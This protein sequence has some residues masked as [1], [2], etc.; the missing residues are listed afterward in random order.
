MLTAV[1]DLVFKFI[2]GMDERKELLQ[3][4]INLILERVGLPLASTIRI[5][6]PFN[7]RQYAD[8]KESVLDIEASDDSGRFFD[9]EMQLEEQ[10][11]YG[12]R[13]MYY[14]SRVYGAQLKMG[15][16]YRAL[17]PVV[18]IH[19]LDFVM[20]KDKTHFI[21]LFKPRDLL[22]PDPAGASIL[23]EQMVQ[24][25]LE[26]PLMDRGQHC[27]RLEKLLLLLE[28]EGGNDTM[29]YSL[30]EQ[31]KIFAEIDEAFRKFNAD[32]E[33]RSI[34]EGHL[35]WQHDHATFLTVARE[36]GEAEG[37]A[38]GEAEGKRETAYD[39]ARR[40]KVKGIDIGLIAE[41]TGLSPEEIAKS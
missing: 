31:E 12:S 39:I 27:G 34:Y 8:D 5:R 9:I 41:C 30:A 32:P 1:N 29:T 24:I 10:D 13:A 16:D 19:I 26:L 22:D 21:K 3:D 40:M 6:N 17:H 35:K 4:F 20:R 37:R 33:L 28:T 36:K 11:Y 15:V 7:L 25:M 2:F 38:K 14:W 18:G 23:S